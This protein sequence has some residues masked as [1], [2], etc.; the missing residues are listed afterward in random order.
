MDGARV[1]NASAAT[2]IAVG[3]ICAS[4]DSVSVCFSKGLGAPAGS[5]FCGRR[6][7]VDEARR[8]RRRWGGAMR[9]AGILAAAAQHALDHHRSRLLDDHANARALAERLA[10]APG[11]TIDLRRVETNLLVIDI[12]APSEIVVREARELGVLVGALG[13]KRLRAVTHL[14]VPQAAVEPAANA[15][16]EALRRGHKHA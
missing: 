12:D 8:F 7:L 14:D 4:F 16:I 9:Q 11:F 15:L 6:A 3:E 1:W 2:G 5:A 10:E 13:P